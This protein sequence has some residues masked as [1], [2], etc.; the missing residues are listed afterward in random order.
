[1]AKVEVM[2]DPASVEFLLF[3]LSLSRKHTWTL[4]ILLALLLSGSRTWF[5]S[6]LSCAVHRCDHADVYVLL[7]IVK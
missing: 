5:G 2:V 7:S 4:L 1:M 3:V 6:L